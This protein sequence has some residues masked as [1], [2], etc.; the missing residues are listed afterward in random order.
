M[1]CRDTQTPDT[2]CCVEIHRYQTLQAVQGYTDIRYQGYT[3]IRHCTLCSD[4][5]TSDTA[6][7]VEIHRHQTLLAM[8]QY[9]GIRHCMLCRNPFYCPYKN[10]IP[11]TILQTVKTKLSAGILNILLFTTNTILRDTN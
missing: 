7:C 4:T 2:A 5:Q 8:K 6:C 1:L 11:F 3:D 10:K 9:T